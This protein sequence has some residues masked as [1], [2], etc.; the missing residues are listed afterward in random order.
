MNQI[1]DPQDLE[2]EIV[3]HELNGK[4]SNFY[5]SIPPK[6]FFPKF[7]ET[8]TTSENT[9]NSS[10]LTTKPMNSN[11]KEKENL[12]NSFLSLPKD[13]SNPKKIIDMADI[14]SCLNKKGYFQCLFF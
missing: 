8:T 2:R 11:E 4:S 13:S 9:I 14:P 10:N 3:S 5:E 6:G 1:R 7:K 12:I